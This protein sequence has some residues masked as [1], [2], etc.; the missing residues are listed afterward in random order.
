[1]L[2]PTYYT[3]AD[4]TFDRIVMRLFWQMGRVKSVGRGIFD[5]LIHCYPKPKQNTIF[6]KT[7]NS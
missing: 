3:T 5:S 4:S 1:M 7:R 6:I 2:C